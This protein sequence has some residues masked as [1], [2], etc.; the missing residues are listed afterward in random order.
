MQNIFDNLKKDKNAKIYRLKDISKIKKGIQLNKNDFDNNGKYYVLN[1]GKEPSGFSNLWNVKSNTITISEGG[2]SCGFV[3]L[4]EEKFYC[5]GHCYYLEEIDEKIDLNYLY[6]SLKYNEH[7]IM[8]LRVGSALPNI[9]KKDI[10]NLKVFI[11][12]LTKQQLIGSLLEKLN[13]KIKI[14]KEKINVLTN[15]KRYM[16][17]N[18]FI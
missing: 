10:E 3:N 8:K 17:R 5:G 1:G 6:F 7:N 14:I 13:Y 11:P 12:N 18:L 15:F 2:N 4:N 9:Q 16:L